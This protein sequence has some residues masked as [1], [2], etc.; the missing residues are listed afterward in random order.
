MKVSLEICLVPIGVGTSVSAYVA[1]CQ[2]VLAEA[3]LEPQMHAYGTNV[4]GE[5]DEVFAA[6]KRCH[7][8]VHDMGAVR[9]FTSLKVGTRT[10]RVQTL[11]DKIT[12][13]EDRLSGKTPG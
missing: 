5:W 6:L 12:S 4:E 13:V 3:G 1:A 9:I 2:T 10:D 11:Q 8:Q 7:E